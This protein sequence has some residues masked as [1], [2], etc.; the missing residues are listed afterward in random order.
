MIDY[1]IYGVAGFVLVSVTVGFGITMFEASTDGPRAE[2]MARFRKLFGSN[3]LAVAVC[4]L[5]LI[6]MFVGLRLIVL[7]VFHV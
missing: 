3:V 5:L 6:L 7:G 1:L 2:Y 4:L